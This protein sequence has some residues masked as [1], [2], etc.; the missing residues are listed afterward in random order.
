MKRLAF[1]ALAIAAL[2]LCATPL[3]TSSQGVPSPAAD[4]ERSI[5]AFREVA[6][7]LQS[8]RCLNCHVKGDRPRQGD[9]RHL[10]AQSVLRGLDGKGLP[11]LRCTNCHQ[12]SNIDSA[13]GPPGVAGWQMPPAATP[14]AWEGLSAGDLCRA[15]TDPRSNGH[16]TGAQVIDHLRTPQVTWAWTPGPERT[17]PPLSY[18]QFMAKAQEWVSTGA[19]CEK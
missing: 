7:V 17:T 12:D 3:L 9:D 5:A 8:P 16:R 4:R 15:V 11:G 14:M 19:I 10:H 6:T 13:G 2:V 18:D 1:A